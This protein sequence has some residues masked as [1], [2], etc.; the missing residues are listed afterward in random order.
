[1]KLLVTGASGFIGKNFLLAAPKEWE[2][3][4][5]FL[6]GE[7]F[8]AFL[9]RSKLENVE[10]VECD[11][12]DK[13]Q[14]GMLERGYDACLHLAANSDPQKSFGEPAEDLK[15]NA[16]TLVNLLEHT[17]FDKFL[18]MS[19]GAV[20]DGLQGSVDPSKTLEP[21][22]PYAISKLAAEQYVKAFRQKGTIG[23]Y[24]ILR[25]FGAYGPFEP[26]RKI[27][28]KLVRTFAIEGRNEYEVYGD[29]SNL[30]DAMYVGDAVRGILKAL[31]GGTWDATFDFCS[32]NPVSINELVKAAAEAF[33]VK[34]VE[35]RHSGVSHEA[36]RFWA[37]P[38]AFEKS[39]RFKPK[40]SLEEG[41][42]LLE[43]HLRK[44]GG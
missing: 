13:R 43:A 23:G 16:M 4:G 8:P 10:P 42:G 26:E 1:M 31:E 29:G 32:G 9:K 28:T 11:L 12:L 30:I 17:K 39:F 5:T 34:G 2:I 21:R 41:L 33:G 27:Y 19:S 40:V 25:F 3:T 6:A 44:T 36:I 35:I 15:S 14:V 7:D 22:L 38:A 24:V 18:F 20:Y 37:S